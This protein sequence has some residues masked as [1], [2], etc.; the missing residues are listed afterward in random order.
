MAARLDAILLCENGGQIRGEDLQGG[1]WN[2]L[3]GLG[4]DE[5]TGLAWI[6]L[7]SWQS[8]VKEPGEDACVGRNR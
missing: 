3:L 5:G 2:L 4:I 7:A 8:M 6:E 1:E